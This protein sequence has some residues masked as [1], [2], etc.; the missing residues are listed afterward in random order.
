M[1]GAI[2]GH[3]GFDPESLGREQLYRQP[4]DIAR[5][6]RLALNVNGIDFSGW[7]GGLLSAA[8]SEADI[9]ATVAGFGESL[10]MLQP[11]LD[12]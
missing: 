6:L 4:P 11:V 12:A 9:D 7:P 1:G 2:A 10:K 5:L 8:H 3:G